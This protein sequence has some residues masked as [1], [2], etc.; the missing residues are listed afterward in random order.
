MWYYQILLSFYLYK[1][2]RARVFMKI[3]INLFLK[4]SAVYEGLKIFKF[5][6]SFWK[7][8]NLTTVHLVIIQI[9]IVTEEFFQKSDIVVFHPSFIIYMHQE[10]QC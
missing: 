1:N 2:I 7:P 5:Q 4:I 8:S 6:I 3:C 10:F 9:K